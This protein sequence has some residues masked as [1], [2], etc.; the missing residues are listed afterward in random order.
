VAQ[1]VFDERDYFVD[2]TFDE[3]E[4]VGINLSGKEFERCVFRRCKLSESRWARAKFE[5]C[6]FEDCDL[7]RIVPRGVSLSGVAF[8]N[9]RLMGVDW[10][11][12]GLVP[13]MSFDG[14]DLRYA[15]FVKAKL[16]KTS[17]VNCVARESTFVDTDLSAANFSD[18]DLTGATFQGCTFAKADFTKAVGFAFDPQA[19][20]VKGARVSVDAAIAF[21]QSFGVAVE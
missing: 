20:R 5:Q 6:R 21:V 12:L 16:Q 1:S 17:L 15:S 4:A 7:A 2:E 19:N 8:T 3:V 13:S 18:T 10:T 11:E 14:C 9:S